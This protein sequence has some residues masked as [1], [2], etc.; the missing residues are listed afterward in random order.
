VW[1]SKT[2]KKLEGQVVSVPHL[3][4]HP[5]ICPVKALQEWVVIR[6]AKDDALFTSLRTG[7][8]LSAQGVA[9][10]VKRAAKRAGF[11]PKDFAAHSLR[12]GFATSAARADAAERDIMEVTRHTSERTLRG[13]I[14]EATLGE[15]H[16]GRKIAEQE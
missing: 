1:G 7:S 9:R 14:H 3:P 13:Y 5:D 6:P 10:V 2:D 8:R 12:S 11:D 16:P 4:E 15:K